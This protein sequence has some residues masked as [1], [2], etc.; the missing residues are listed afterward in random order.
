MRPA[1]GRWDGIAII[2]IGSLPIKRPG[3][4]P[5]DG[6]LP[7]GKFG[8]SG[9]EIG[10]GAFPF[11]ELLAQMVGKAT[12]KLESCRGGGVIADQVRRAAPAD[13]DTA[14]QIGL[15]TGQPIKSGRLEP[16]LGPENLSV[17]DEADRRAAPVGSGPE[18]LQRCGRQSA[19]KTL[20]EQF[21]VARHFNDEF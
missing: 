7:I 5:F 4:R 6:T 15:G 1:I 21:L 16:G 19:R 20:P 2:A 9:K 10:G 8:A 18:L 12:G 11:A 3:D 13:F 17:G 14:E